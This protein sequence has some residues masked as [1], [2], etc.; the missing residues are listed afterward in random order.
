MAQCSLLNQR[1]HAQGNDSSGSEQL[2]EAAGVISVGNF[3]MGLKF[4]GKNPRWAS[5]DGFWANLSKTKQSF[6]RHHLIPQSD[7]PYDGS[8]IREHGMRVGACNGLLTLSMQFS[9]THINHGYERKGQK[10]S[11]QH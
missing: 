9:Q 4:N 6:R 2:V 8:R 10:S 5:A 11:I 3:R 1:T 7:V